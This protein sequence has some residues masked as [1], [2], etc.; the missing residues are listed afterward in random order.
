MVVVQP[1]LHVPFDLYH[2]LVNT[3]SDNQLSSDSHE[4]VMNEG[5]NALH[6]FLPS[7]VPT[8]RMDQF[9]H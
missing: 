6:G 2:R 1:P 9:S 5:E 8:N 7:V 3:I 4:K